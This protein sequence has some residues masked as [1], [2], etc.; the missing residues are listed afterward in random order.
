MF[1]WRFVFQFLF[2]KSEEK[3]VTRKKVSKGTDF[4]IPCKMLNDL[5][6]A[7]YK[8]TISAK[9]LGTLEALLRLFV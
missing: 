8:P 5:E 9:S 1:N 2:H 6:M 3:I 7:F 4:S